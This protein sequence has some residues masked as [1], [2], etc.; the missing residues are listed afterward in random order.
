MIGVTA[1][2]REGLEI[3]FLGTAVGVDFDDLAVVLPALGKL[4]LRVGRGYADKVRE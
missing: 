1:A 3:N 2:L 4:G